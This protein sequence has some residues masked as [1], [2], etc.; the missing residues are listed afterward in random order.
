M[1][2]ADM[3]QLPHVAILRGELVRSGLIDEECEAGGFGMLSAAGV[4][5]GV[6]FRSRPAWADGDRSPGFAAHQAST[7]VSPAWI[8]PAICPTRL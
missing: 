5:K 4:A 8:C 1:T 3:Q 2:V 7:R 6:P